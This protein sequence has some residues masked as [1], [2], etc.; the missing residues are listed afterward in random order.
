MDNCPIFYKSLYNSTASKIKVEQ[1][2]ESLAAF[3]EKQYL[4][5]FHLLMDYVDPELR[6]RYGN[7]DGTSFRIPHGSIIVN[8]AI[9]KESFSVSAPFLE[10]N[11]STIVPLLRQVC[12]L[13]FTELDLTQIYLRDNRLDFEY[14]CKIN[15]T[16]PYKIYY[17][18]REICAT[19]D[20][21]DDEYVTK[22]NAKRLYEPIITPFPAEKAEIAYQTILAII[23]QSL[24]YTTYFESKRNYTQAWDLID[25]TLRQIDYYVHPQ[26]QLKNDIAQAVKDANDEKPLPGL[27]TDVKI[28]LEE[29]QTMD[30]TK[31][32]ENLYSIEIFIPNKRRSSLQNIQ[33]NLEKLYER[34][35]KGMEDGYHAAITTDILFNFYNVY[36]HNNV[37]EDVNQLLVDAMERSSGK[38][39]EAAASI[40]FGALKK[41]MDGE[42]ATPKKAGLLSRLFGK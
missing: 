28:F 26:G 34:A 20:Q 13:N 7:T 29:L 11:Q 17:I 12:S 3:D 18:L 6:A 37:Q 15:E 31:L 30:K 16:N 36:Y 4:K 33:E 10:I 42:L 2:D 19:G 25:G 38:P 32:L 24:E 40:L 14:S 39:W 21:Y 27:I 35:A 22:F 5:S 9:D 8:I 41:I 1:W 23:K